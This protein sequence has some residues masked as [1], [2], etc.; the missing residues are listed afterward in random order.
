VI[1][2]LFTKKPSLGVRQ[3]M[4]VEGQR[5]LGRQEARSDVNAAHGTGRRLADEEYEQA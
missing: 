4:A 3:M 5:L 2:V 1:D